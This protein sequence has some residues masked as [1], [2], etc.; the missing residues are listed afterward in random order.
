ML[1]T[2]SSDEAQ[3]FPVSVPKNDLPAEFPAT[4]EPPDTPALPAVLS[5]RDLVVLLLLIVVS[6]FNTNNVQAAGPSAF[7][8][9][10]LGT[11]T[12]LIPCAYVTQW[13]GRRFPGQGAPYL[14]ATRILGPRWGFIAAFCA[15]LPGALAVVASIGSAITFIQYL[16]P[17]WLTTPAQQ[18]IATLLLLVIPAAMSCLPLQRLRPILLAVAVLYVGALLLL[19]VAGIG[20]LVIGH[21][22][23]TALTPSATWLPKM[24]TISIF[25][26]VILAFLGVDNPLFMGG[27]I[28]GGASGARR[29]TRYVWW[30]SAL[31]LLAYLAGTFGLMVIVPP[32]QA[33]GVNANV[34][35]I[36]LVF[37]PTAG[38]I[39]AFVLAASQVILTIAYLLTF[40]RLLVVAAQA[41]RL[42]MAL[43]R[44]NRHG[45]PILSIVIQAIVVALVTLLTLVVIPLLFRGA[46][47]AADAATASYTLM[48]GC[49]TVVWLISVI[50]MFGLVG[51]FLYRQKGR[52]TTALREQAVL[53]LMCLLGSAASLFGLWATLSSSWAPALVSNGQW[54]FL[55]VGITLV[56]LV[57]GLMVGE[58]PRMHALLGEQKRLH[59]REVGLRQQLQDAYTRQQALVTE[60]QAAQEVLAAL[61]STDP[62]TGLLN[63]RTF[64]EYL[65]NEVGRA[66]RYGHPLSLLFFDGDR[67]KR[68]NDSYGHV[69]GDQVLRELGERTRTALRAGDTLGRYG[70]EEFVVLLPETDQEEALAVAERIRL[71]VATFPLA[72][73]LVE[74]GIRA[75]ISIGVASYPRDGQTC[76]EVIEQADQAM[77]WAKRLGRNQVCSATKA[78]RLNR[79]FRLLPTSLPDRPPEGAH[80]AGDRDREAH[81]DQLGS[82]YPLMWVLDVRDHGIFAHAHQVSD[83]A[84]AI[85]REMGLDDQQCN[86]IAIAGLLHDIGK[87]AIPDAI[88]QKP[89]PLTEAEWEIVRQHPALG[90]QILEIS[91]TLHPLMSFIRHHHERWDGAGYPDH[92]ADAHIP[93]EARIIAVADTYQTITATRAYQ[94]ARSPEVACEEIQRCSGGQFDP[95][96][97]QVFMQVMARYQEAALSQPREAA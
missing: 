64:V 96:V 89:G 5:Q 38:Q 7:A 68:V 21:H 25:G 90:A 30:G 34:L 83:L 53:L 67:F 27:E 91:P 15:W 70:G 41:R 86:A 66:R 58:L 24:G 85:A 63:H 65:E 52:R 29:A 73:T 17:T 75:T 61:A 36:Q 23:A 16:A 35:A 42:P 80:E 32:E 97:V 1:P 55:L 8:Y 60:L 39:M 74:G 76:A 47:A 77:Y 2:P 48:E 26:V 95:A 59:A 62:L 19:G 6:I 33:G 93:L 18:A 13:L 12:F 45:V 28:H 43:T 69:I 51:W 31:T 3:A 46:M 72:G 57:G 54:V 40:S 79:N 56:A 9:W 87:I 49:T 84:V 14:W 92:L 94:A 37:G 44:L 82:L 20:W 78:H 88:L 11:L 4:A 50:Q 22:A 71:A 81:L 10:A